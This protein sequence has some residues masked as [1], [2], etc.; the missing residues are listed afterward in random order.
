MSEKQK[1]MMFVT[2]REILSRTKTKLSTL[3]FRRDVLVKS[4]VEDAERIA[5]ENLK[6]KIAE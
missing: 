4:A 1:Q 2:L 5:I 6:K 3:E